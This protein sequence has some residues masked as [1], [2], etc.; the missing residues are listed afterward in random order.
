MK[1]TAIEI[2]REEFKREGIEPVKIYLFGSQVNGRADNK[3]DWDFLVI[4]NKELNRDEKW[5]II[6]KIKRR[7]AK[8]RIPND[9]VINSVKQIEERAEDTGFITYYALKYGVQV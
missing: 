2:I 6:L 7:L 3:S 9:I 5:S 8:L 1:E 4:I